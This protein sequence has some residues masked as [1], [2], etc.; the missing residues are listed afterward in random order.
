MF[1]S[2]SSKPKFAFDLTIN[3]LTNVPQI[4][5]SCYIEISIKDSKRNSSRRHKNGKAPVDPSKTKTSNSSTSSPSRSNTRSFLN[6][7]D[8]LGSKLK[9]STSLSKDKSSSSDG[10]KNNSNSS[11]NLN[12]S[13]S[14]S[15]TSVSGHV[16]TTTSRKRLHN[17]RCVFNYKLSCNLKFGLKKKGNLISNKYLCFRVYYIHEDKHHSSDSDNGTIIDLGRLEINLAEYLNFSDPVNTK[18]LLE[19]SKVNSILN[20]TIGLHELPSNFDFHTQ[21]QIQDNNSS[22]LSSTSTSNL[23]MSNK[24]KT[25]FNVPQFEKKNV[26]T[27][28][29]NVLGD[30]AIQEDATKDHYQHHHHHHHQHDQNGSKS[31]PR[32]HRQLLNTS[33]HS[34]N[35]VNSSSTSSSTSSNKKTQENKSL[36]D[37]ANLNNQ[38][39][40]KLV[41]QSSDV[42]S[43]FSSNQHPAND[44][45]SNN[46]GNLPSMINQ[47]S[48]EDNKHILMDPIVSILYCKILESN[49]DPELYPLLD[50]S[51]NQCIDDI[52]NNEQ[53]PL[54]CNLK[55]KKF[56][57]DKKAENNKEDINDDSYRELNGLINEVKYRPNLQSWTINEE[58]YTK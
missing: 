3:E 7:F 35:S 8:D 50:Y 48:S 12:S 34:S 40:I 2:S 49:W 53:N 30:N 17:F 23:N 26:Y 41:A 1:S 31:P 27:G 9:Q 5:G 56:Y 13:S 57:L 54:G 24:K 6:K 46:V 39:L 38:D 18:Y 21:L 10:N 43:G 25:N 36:T 33:K 4:N 29:N 22:N 55:L 52:F 14:N 47:N 44:S 42:A 11:F 20:I 51:P 16:S 32:N 15:N 19:D 45:N 28:I 58:I 37:I